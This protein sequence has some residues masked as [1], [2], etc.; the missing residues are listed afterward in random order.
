MYVKF[1]FISFYKIKRSQ[2]I[3]E[4]KAP[5]KFWDYFSAGF[6]N[7]AARDIHIY[8]LLIIFTKYYNDYSV[9]TQHNNKN[10]ASLQGGFSKLKLSFFF[11]PVEKASTIFLRAPYKNKLA[12][13]N[14]VNLKYKFIIVIKRPNL[15]NYQQSTPQACRFVVNDQNNIVAFLNNLDLSTS[16]IR[17]YKTEFIEFFTHRNNFFLKEFI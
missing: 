13:L 4:L 8:I 14:I 5:N 3:K 16:K 7:P 17:H 11:P 1:R 9:Q 10:P 6:Y 15:N 2:A 12:R